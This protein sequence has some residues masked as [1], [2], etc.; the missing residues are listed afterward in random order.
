LVGELDQLCREA[1][2]QAA[3]QT[4]AEHLE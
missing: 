1:G 4:H 2:A 3:H